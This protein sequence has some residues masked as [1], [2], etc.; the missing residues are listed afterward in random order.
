MREALRVM[1]EARRVTCCCTGLP[2]RSCF[3]GTLPTLRPY[4]LGGW[5][6]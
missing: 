6:V 5:A 2:L 4:L 1:G 3:N